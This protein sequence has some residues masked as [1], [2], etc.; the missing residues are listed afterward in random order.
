MKRYEFYVGKRVEARYRTGYI[1]YA[2]TGT[3]TVDSGKCIFVEDRFVQDGRQKTIR[4]EIPYD[5][6][7]GV[8]ELTIAPA[9]FK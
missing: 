8:A 2:A 7:L 9:Q 1:Y 3:L 6:I 5:C 4:V